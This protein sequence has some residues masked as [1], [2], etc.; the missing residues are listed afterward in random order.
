MTGFDHFGATWLLTRGAALVKHNAVKRRAKFPLQDDS[1]LC[2]NA[3]SNGFDSES[4]MRIPSETAALWI[5][6]RQARVS[7]KEKAAWANVAQNARNCPRQVPDIV[8]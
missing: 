1:G 4:K 6:D 3:I 5:I 7:G 8:Q 2:G